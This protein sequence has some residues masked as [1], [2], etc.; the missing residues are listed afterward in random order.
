MRNGWEFGVLVMSKVFGGSSEGEV[1][2]EDAGG[3]EEGLSFFG[4]RGELVELLEGF[5]NGGT[6]GV[7]AVVTFEGLEKVHIFGVSANFTIGEAVHP[8]ARVLPFSG[9][10][11]VSVPGVGHLGLGVIV[12][13][14]AAATAGMVADLADGDG[15]I[16]VFA[17]VGWEGRVLDVF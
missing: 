2:A 5:V 4:P 13:I 14:L 7:D 15:G 1:G 6:V 9:G 3:E 8:A 11:E 12:P 17:K 16:A 10:E